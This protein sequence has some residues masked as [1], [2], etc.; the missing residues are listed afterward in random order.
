MLPIKILI[1]W[2]RRSAGQICSWACQWPTYLLRIYCAVWQKTQLSLHSQTQ[3]LKFA[4]DLA[5]ATKD[6]VIMATGRSDYPNQVNNVLG[7]PYIFRGALDVHATAINEEMKIAAV[8]AIAELT[9]KPVPHIVNLAYNRPDLAFGPE[10]IIPKPIDP[11]LIATVA[12]AVAKAAIKSG[13]ARKE[14]TRLGCLRRIPLCQDGA[15]Q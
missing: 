7:F 2:K 15:Q 10:Y 14:I 12:P 3:I 11:R 1:H 13:V 5:L 6:D 4:Y 8:K 9:K